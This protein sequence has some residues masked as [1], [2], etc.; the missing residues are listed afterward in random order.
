MMFW[1]H[2]LSVCNLGVSD[3]FGHFSNF[4]SPRYPA[5]FLQPLFFQPFQFP[6]F[7]ADFALSLLVLA[8]VIQI[9]FEVI[10]DHL[11]QKGFAAD[12]FPYSPIL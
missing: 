9:L 2:L 11:K 3:L 10:F 7:L 4:D 8:R 5:S 1:K 12:L 6:E